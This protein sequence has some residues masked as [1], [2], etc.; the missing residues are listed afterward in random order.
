MADR[1][2]FTKTNVKIKCQF[3]GKIFHQNCKGIEMFFPY[4]LPSDDE[5]QISILDNDWSHVIFRRVKKKK[6]Q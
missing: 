6:E 3:S 1:W 5:K 4:C 2:H